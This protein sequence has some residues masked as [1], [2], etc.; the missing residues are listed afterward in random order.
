MQSI[1]RM[2][3]EKHNILVHVSEARSHASTRPAYK[4][5][6]S[7]CSEHPAC[8]ADPRHGQRPGAEAIIVPLRPRS[9]E[10]YTGRA[11]QAAAARLLQGRHLAAGPGRGK[12]SDKTYVLKH[13]A[14]TVG[15]SAWE[16][17][18]NKSARVQNNRQLWEHRAALDPV[19]TDATNSSHTQISHC[20]Q[21]T[22]QPRKKNPCPRAE[23]SK[24]KQAR[25]S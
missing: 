10:R 7:Q 22:H 8:G 21:S 4:S 13:P 16:T 11:I 1:A 5:H 9:S 19:G 17:S 20:S 6:R 18:E 3:D 25:M 23:P 14:L 12:A 24:N 2:H 15:A